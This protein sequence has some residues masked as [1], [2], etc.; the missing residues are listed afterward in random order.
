MHNFYRRSTNVRTSFTVRLKSY[1]VVLDEKK[2]EDISE[3]TIEHVF[4][5]DW[6]GAAPALLSV[7]QS[8]SEVVGRLTKLRAELNAK[9]AERERLQ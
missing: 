7:R 2:F 1:G 9:T 5:Q 6:M 8:E 3:G 4:S